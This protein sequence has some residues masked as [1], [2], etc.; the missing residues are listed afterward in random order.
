[1]STEKL[2]P[3]ELAAAPAISSSHSLRNYCEMPRIFEE[4]PHAT[5]VCVSRPDAGDISPL[6]LSYTIEVQYKQVRVI[7]L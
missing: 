6:L 1:M 2:I 5:I 3:E 7:A 4:L